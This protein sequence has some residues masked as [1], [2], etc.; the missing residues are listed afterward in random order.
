VHLL[1]EAGKVRAL[2]ST[3]RP[4][5]LLRTINMRTTAQMW[6]IYV[7]RWLFSE[8]H[9]PVSWCSDTFPLTTSR[10]VVNLRLMDVVIIL[11][12]LTLILTSQNMTGATA[13]FILAFAS[14]I[15]AQVN[16]LLI[17]LRQIEVQGVSLERTAK[18]R[19]LELEEGEELNV[20]DQAAQE[21]LQAGMYRD[22]DGW[23]NK[24][25]I[26]VE[27]LSA[28]Y[29]PDLPDILHEV[30]FDIPGGQSVGIVGATGGGKS[31]LAK[32]FFS[33]VDITHGK[34]EIDGKSGSALEFGCSKDAV[35]F[36]WERQC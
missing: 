9:S 21:A 26:K 12:A 29:G 10:A 25:E 31:T 1:D 20:N 28:S 6:R 14:T 17:E 18:Y 4:A 3:L 24:G 8:P 34:I 13:G 5:E 33:F 16:W 32:A 19:A 36:T 35:L 27:E 22:Y 7:S 23:P 30:S 11:T 15:T 2:I